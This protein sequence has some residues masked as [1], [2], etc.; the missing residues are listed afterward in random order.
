[1]HRRFA[2]VAYRIRAAD[3]VLLAFC[4]RDPIN[5]VLGRDPDQQGNLAGASQNLG[6][7]KKSQYH[8]GHG[9][10]AGGRCHQ[11][12]DDL[13]G[14]IGVSGARS[15]DKDEPCALAGVA[16]YADKLKEINA[17]GP[18]ETC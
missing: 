5:D 14:V 16:K 18:Q 15:S 12:G 4:W 2:H 8:R 13:L 1:M 3:A 10:S 7:S 11:A 9:R 17:K 6:E